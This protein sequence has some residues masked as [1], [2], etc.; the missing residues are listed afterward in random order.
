MKNVLSPVFFLRTVQDLSPGNGATQSEQFRP[1]AYL[2]G[3]S[4]LIKL[5]T[6]REMVGSG[7]GYA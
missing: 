5:T 3:D 1:E 7:G 2:S 6:E 4:N